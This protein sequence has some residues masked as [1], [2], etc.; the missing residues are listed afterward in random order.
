MT[1]AE[2]KRRPR[3][4]EFSV[5]LGVLLAVFAQ[6]AYDTLKT[7]YQ[8]NASPLGP[9]LP[10]LWAGVATGT[11][12]IL[13]YFLHRKWGQLFTVSDKESANFS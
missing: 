8:L 6:A 2:P 4:D 3:L 10:S 5:V 12:I 13:L 7:F 11:L 9:Y 1:K